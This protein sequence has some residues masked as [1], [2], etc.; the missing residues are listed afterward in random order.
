M[1]IISFC[2]RKGGAKST[3]TFNISGLIADSG[4]KVLMVDLD[5]QAGLSIMCDNKDNKYTISNV[6][7][8]EIKAENAVVSMSNNLDLLPA[9]IS[10]SQVGLGLSEKWFKEY[11]LKDALNSI[12]DDYDYILIDCNAYSELL[13]INAL[14]ASDAVIIPCTDDYIGMREVG[15][16]LDVMDEVKDRLNKELKLI[17]IIITSSENEV[18]RGVELEK[19]LKVFNVPII[20]SINNSEDVVDSIIKKIPLHKLRPDHV[21]VK[22]YCKV[23]DAI[24]NE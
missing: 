10:L 12:K 14:A 16:I 21:V 6:L 18:S 15:R 1:N 3:L 23:K 4:K 24:L 19:I 22:Q 5:P 13:Q 9:S 17:G 2:N 8:R 7:R 20:T 11:L